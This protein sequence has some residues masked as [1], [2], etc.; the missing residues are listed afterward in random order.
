MFNNIKGLGKKIASAGVVSLVAF[1]SEAPAQATN[2][3]APPALQ[4]KDGA[5]IIWEDPLAVGSV[6]A[7]FPEIQRILDFQDPTAVNYMS[8]HPK[9]DLAD[10]DFSTYMRWL[11]AGKLSDLALSFTESAKA[12]SRYQSYNPF[13]GV[14]PDSSVCAI[15]DEINANEYFAPADAPLAVGFTTQLI[16]C[17][18]GVGEQFNKTTRGALIIGFSNSESGTRAV[19]LDED[20]LTESGA[21]MRHMPKL[22]R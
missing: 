19:F 6:R 9:F 5:P 3:S 17:K 22:R 18:E 21:A 4:N 2:L 10:G 11:D 8:L 20:F 14:L 16:A 12:P 13:R 1:F 7:R 15:F